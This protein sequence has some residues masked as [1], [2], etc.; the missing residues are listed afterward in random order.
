MPDTMLPGWIVDN[1]EDAS[2]P[3][4]KDAHRVQVVLEI[5]DL[6]TGE[7]RKG[8]DHEYV[9]HKDN[10]EWSDFNWSENNFSCDCNRHL[11]FGRL[12]GEELGDDTVK[13]GWP[14]YP[15]G[16]FEVRITNPATGDV[17]YED[18]EWDA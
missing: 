4:Y 11:F 7:V 8:N 14:E 3:I 1:P 12:G 10:G 5:R 15:D 9:W 16:R 18:G 17:M 2:H 13:C 6:A